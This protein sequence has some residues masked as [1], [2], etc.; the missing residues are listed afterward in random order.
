MKASRAAVKTMKAQQTTEER[1]TA[2]EQRIARIEGLL[3]GE[4]IT[5]SFDPVTDDL[6]KVVH[7]ELH[8]ALDPSWMQAKSKRGTRKVDD[9]DGH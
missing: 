2:I 9:D 3:T 1:L 5:I 7:E 6:R 8:K 4:N